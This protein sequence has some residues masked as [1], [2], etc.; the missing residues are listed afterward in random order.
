M[1]VNCYTN[2]IKSRVYSG[3]FLFFNVYKSFLKKFLIRL[4]IV[5]FAD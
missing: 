4:E 1:K 5:I 3:F 2:F